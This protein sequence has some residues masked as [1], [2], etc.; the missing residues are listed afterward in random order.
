MRKK[1]LYDISIIKH[2]PKEGECGF[3]EYCK[4]IEKENKRLHH[5]NTTGNTKPNDNAKPIDNAEPID[6]DVFIG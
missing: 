4:V 1:R 3:P 2:P 5:R 6:T